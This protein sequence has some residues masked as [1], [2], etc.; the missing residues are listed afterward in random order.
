MQSYLIQLASGHPL[1]LIQLMK[2]IP[3]FDRHFTIGEFRPTEEPMVGSLE[4]ALLI[5]MGTHV[6][7][8]D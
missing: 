1:G 6:L 3:G 4:L 7:S 2:R 8:D 5:P